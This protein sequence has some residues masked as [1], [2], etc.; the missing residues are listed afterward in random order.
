MPFGLSKASVLGAAGSG[1]DTSAMEVIATSTSTSSYLTFSAIPQ[2]FKHLR[3]VTF[4]PGGTANNGNYYLYGVNAG[5]NY[6]RAS[7]YWQSGASVYKNGYDFVAGDGFRTDVGGSS[8][9]PNSSMGRYFISTWLYYSDAAGSG[10]STRWSSAQSEYVIIKQT[11][12]NAWMGLSNYNEYGADA[13]AAQPVT[14]IN[15]EFSV[16]S[17]SLPSGTTT[18][19]YGFG[20]D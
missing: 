19:L 1:G 20:G 7:I 11:G 8:V 3:L 9:T 5:V 6:S 14:S 16:S 15:R 10:T 13:N 17:E 4:V 2:T 18:T 12:G